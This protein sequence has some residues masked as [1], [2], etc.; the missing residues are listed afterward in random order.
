MMIFSLGAVSESSQAKDAGLETGL[1]GGIR[2]NEQMQ[3]SDEDIYAVEDAMQ[4]RHSVSGKEALIAL[5]GPP[6]SRAEW[7]SAISADLRAL[8]GGF[9]FSVIKILGMTA[10]SNGMNEKMA[11]E[12]ENMKK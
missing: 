9:G 3:T 12:G 8:I 5:K 4:V 7:L 11:R 1:R 6:T 2:V 10:A